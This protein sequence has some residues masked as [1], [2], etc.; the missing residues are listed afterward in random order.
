[1]DEDRRDDMRLVFTAAILASGINIEYL[2]RAEPEQRTKEMHAIANAVV[3]MADKVIQ[4]LET[5]P[6]GA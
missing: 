5:I 3:Q 1:M 6:K 2:R 4:A